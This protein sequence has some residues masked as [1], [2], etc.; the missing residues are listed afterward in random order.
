MP[1]EFKPDWEATQARFRTYWAG[2][3][4]DRCALAVTAPRAGAPSDPPPPVPATPYAR[5]TDLDYA[6]AANTHRMRRTFYG[7]EAFPIWT[8]GYPGHTAIPTF[9][10]C[11]IDLDFATGWWHPIVTGDGLTDV[12]K[13]RVDRDGAWWQFTLQMLERAAREAAGRC[14]PSIGAFGGCGDTLAALRGTDRLLFDVLDRPDE[15]VAV[16]EYLMTMWCDVFDEFYRLVR[17]VSGGSTCWFGFWS[18]GKTYAAHNDFSYMISPTMFRRLFLPIIERQT[19]F[20]D[21][22]VYH[23]DGIGAFVHVPA[24]CEL[25][26]LQAIQI[27]PGAGKPSPLHYLDTLKYVQRAGKNLQ[28]HL[29]AEE[30]EPALR[31]LS[32]RGLFITT[33]C[34]TEAQARQLLKDAMK[35]SHD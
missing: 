11:P 31:A 17:E 35:W 13:L 10:G 32:A 4:M 34:K 22:T 14:I 1:L 26:R 25:P 19:R 30:V 9:L 21:H 7:G 20:L 12:L 33:W 23:V 5:W 3:A 18:P 15:V 6:A 16:E 8:V 29:P 24:L 28:I 2:E 27:L